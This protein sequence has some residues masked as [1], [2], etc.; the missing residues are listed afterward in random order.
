VVPFK[1]S[2]VC[3]S[4]PTPGKAACQ[5]CRKKSLRRKR[6][7]RCGGWTEP[8]SAWKNALHLL[9]LRGGLGSPRYNATPEGGA[10]TFGAA[11][12]NAVYIATSFPGHGIVE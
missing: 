4:T 1:E 6:R 12:R 3:R 10:T 8:A 9:L 2:F 5:S 7:G 11:K